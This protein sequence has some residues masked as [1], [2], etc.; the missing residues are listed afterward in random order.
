MISAVLD[1][2]CE[3]NAA[4]TEGA[5]YLARLRESELSQQGTGDRLEQARSKISLATRLLAYGHAN[6]SPLRLYRSIELFR[7][8]VEHDLQTTTSEQRDSASALAASA[9]NLRG[10][11]LSLIARHIDTTSPISALTEAAECANWAASLF[12]SLGETSEAAHCRA[13]GKKYRIELAALCG[14]EKLDKTTDSVP[15]STEEAIEDTETAQHQEDKEITQGETTH[16]PINLSKS[17]VG[18]SIDNLIETFPPHPA[19]QAL[20]ARLE[21]LIRQAQADLPTRKTEKVDFVDKIN[22][23]LDSFHLRLQAEGE[24]PLARLTMRKSSIQLAFSK[25]GSGGF[26]G[27]GQIRVVPVPPRYAFQG[28][29]PKSD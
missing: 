1:L 2:E 6:K 18:A 22:L 19:P 5:A 28:L 23:L 14:S 12:E 10:Q 8:V 27:A 26:K 4:M 9:T 25:R 11:A 7:S 17:F 24:K 29:S 21:V 16:K 20:I 15:I 3:I 13:N